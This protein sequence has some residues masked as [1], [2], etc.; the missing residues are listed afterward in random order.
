MAQNVNRLVHISDIH[1]RNYKRHA[2]YR[3]VFDSLY[4]YL[5]NTHTKDTLIVLTGDIVHSKTDVSPELYQEVQALL[6]SLCEIGKVLMIP[7][8]HDANLANSDRL[9]AL[10][11]IVNALN[12]DNL[13]Y[14]K[15]SGIKTVGNVNFYHWSVFDKKVD[16]PKISTAGYNV[17]LY[18]GLV[19]AAVNDYGYVM[20]SD[21]MKAVDFSGF[22]LTLLGDIHT[23]QYLNE[24]KTIAYPGSLI[25]QNHGESI[26][27]HG[28]LV[29]D[30]ESMTSNFVKIPNK[31]AY[32]TID[33]ENGVCPTLPSN[34]PK[35]L[36]LRVRHKNTTHEDLKSILKEIKENYKLIEISSVKINDFKNNSHNTSQTNV[37]DFRNVDSQNEYIKQYFSGSLMISDEEIKQICEINSTI[38]HKLISSEAPRNTVWTP[39]YFEFENMFGYQKGNSIDFSNMKG[40]YGIFAPNASGK[41]TFLDSITYCIFDKCSKTS[42]ASDVMNNLSDSFQCKFVFELN[43]KEYTIERKAKTQRGGNIRVDVDFFYVDDI[44]AKVSMNGKERTDTNLNIKK[45]LGSYEDFILTS[46]S[47][48][49]GNASFI[50][51]NQRERKELLCQFMDLNVFE[52]LYNLA[53]EESKEINVLLKDLQRVD[54]QDKHKISEQCVSSINKDLEETI[55]NKN[56]V[57]HNQELI[58][59]DLDCLLSKISK[60]DDSLINFD[61]AK[62]EQSIT[63]IKDKVVEYDNLLTEKQEKYFEINNQLSVDENSFNLYDKETINNGKIVLEKL[64]TQHQKTVLK[65]KQLEIEN[66]GMLDKMEK[67]QDLKYDESCDFCMNNIFVKDAIETKNKISDHNTQLK[68]V[69]VEIEELL[70]NIEIYSEFEEEEK[71][72]NELEKLI[73]KNKLHKSIL[74]NSIDTITSDKKQALANIDTI[75]NKINLFELQSNVIESNKQIEKSRVELSDKLKA[76]KREEESLNEKYTTLQ[77][78]KGACVKDLDECKES[79][80]KL[81]EYETKKKLYQ[82]YLECIHRDGIPHKL[83]SDTLPQVQDEVNSVLSQLVEFRVILTT[84]HKNINGYIAYSKDRFWGL[85][86]VSGMEKFIVSLAIRSALISI[87]SLPRPNFL[88]IDEGFGSLDKE[89]LN[90]IVTFFDYLKTQFQFTAIISHI[91]YLRDMVDSIIEI[92]KVDGVSKIHHK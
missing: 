77:V 69:N 21:Y 73:G 59:V 78:K 74:R 50:D 76:L 55:L 34:L 51:I 35:N 45:L 52:E 27:G 91:E 9:D 85:E 37:I 23:N 31:T 24:K 19:N 62:S 28:I 82:C 42:K 20:K 90:S 6:T 46:F 43:G 30:I 86:L 39:K 87:S 48:Q 33:I 7:G 1:L 54:W 57:K 84:D 63:N 60:I 12:L 67:L 13:I 2:E 29:W 56:N 81:T 36:Y 58:Q 88:L 70:H 64:K 75:T 10:T 92:T 47:T 61:K 65:L 16:Y 72:Y 32:F 4:F 5:K 38:N 44:G 11:P 25:Q 8:N 66:K 79:I 3:E 41:S 40:T 14:F 53:N 49:S 18:H 26:D 71:K 22:D 89:N 80:Q 17:C 83:I 15:E 68:I